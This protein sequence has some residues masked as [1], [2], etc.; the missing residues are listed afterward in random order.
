VVFAAPDAA[1]IITSPHAVPFGHAAERGEGGVCAESVRVVAGDDQQ[2]GGGF[3]PD[4]RL[5]EQARRRLLVTC[6]VV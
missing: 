5:G 3:G 1:L 2:L 6:A 4:G